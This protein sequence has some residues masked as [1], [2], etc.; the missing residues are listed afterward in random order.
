MSGNLTQRAGSISVRP[1]FAFVLIDVNN[2]H[3]LPASLREAWAQAR[4]TTSVCGWKTSLIISRVVC[5]FGCNAGGK[6]GQAVTN[7]SCT[8]AA[9]I[10]NLFPALQLSRA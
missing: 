2:G 8:V 3:A 1:Y 10:C 5:A 7:R 6:K 9:R 4:S